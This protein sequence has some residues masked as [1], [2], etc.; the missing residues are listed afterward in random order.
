MN[1]RLTARVLRP[2]DRPPVRLQE[3]RAGRVGD[4]RAYF[5][6]THGTIATPVITRAALD[7]TPRRGPLLVDEYDATTLVPPGCAAHLDPH[8]NI[9]IVIASAGARA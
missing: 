6:P 2:A 7:A 5:G 8:G 1:L 9:V 4:R 3:D